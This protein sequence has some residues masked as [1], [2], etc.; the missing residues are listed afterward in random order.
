MDITQFT[1][2]SRPD[3][4]QDAVQAGE[5]IQYIMELRFGNDKDYQPIFTS[6]DAS[7]NE[8]DITSSGDAI[9]TL[10]KAEK[11][12]PFIAGQSTRYAEKGDR[13]PVLGYTGNVGPNTTYPSV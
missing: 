12:A 2:A 3:A 8:A 1:T 6:V 7:L 13:F 5:N 4:V 11:K 9:Y 10:T